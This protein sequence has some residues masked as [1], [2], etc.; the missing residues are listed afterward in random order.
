MST[1]TTEE[2]PLKPNNNAN[3]DNNNDNDDN[4]EEKQNLVV[5]QDGE[6]TGPISGFKMML[7]ALMV[8]QNSSTVLVG[9]YTRSSV[10][11]DEVFVV[12]HLVLITELAKV[13]VWD[14]NSSVCF[15]D[16]T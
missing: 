14:N 7:L 9:R 5:A 3:N 16:A 2:V 6:T 1:T 15:W 11:A 10:P 12:N 8:L 13:C 4:D